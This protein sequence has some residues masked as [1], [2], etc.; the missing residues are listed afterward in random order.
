MNVDETAVRYVPASPVGLVCPKAFWPSLLVRP[1]CTA[2][3]GDLRGCFTYMGVI[4]NDARVQASL[5]HIVIANKSR[6]K[7]ATFKALK[8]ETRGKPV[9]LWREKS[10]WN[11]GALMVRFSR[12]LCR[13]LQPWRA[14]FEVHLILDVAPCH[15]AEA[16][17]KAAKTLR[18]KL[19]FVPAQLTSILQP[20]DTHG[21]ASFKRWLER[22]KTDTC[23]EIRGCRVGSMHLRIFLLLGHGHLLLTQS[24]LQDTFRLSHPCCGSMRGQLR[25]HVQQ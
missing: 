11:N 13:A 10:S 20:L 8:S 18:I 7:E 4:C 2:R 15:I 16:V 19:I 12:A 9:Q 3:K 23:L 25:R 22:K 1:S 21:Y 6:L 24:E 5:P 14:E 17:L